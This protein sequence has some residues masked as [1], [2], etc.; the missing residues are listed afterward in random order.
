MENEEMMESGEK[1]IIENNFGEPMI[2]G[3]FYIECIANCLCQG[4]IEGSNKVAEI[5][6][7]SQPFDLEGTLSSN[8]ML[9]VITVANIIGLNVS[10]EG[11]SVTIRF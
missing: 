7:S 11:D 6:V 1:V 9:I 4:F 3:I 10:R 2:S 5:I 8:A